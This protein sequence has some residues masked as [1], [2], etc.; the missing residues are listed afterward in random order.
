MSTTLEPKTSKLIADDTE[1]RQARIA[2]E[3]LAPAQLDHW[4]VAAPSGSSVT[5]PTELSSLLTKILQA[6]AEG[7]TV[8]VSTMPEDVTTTTAATMLGV[9]RPTLMKMVANGDIASH[10]VGSHTRLKSTDVQEFKRARLA[11]QRAAFEE[12]LELEGE[13]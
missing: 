13:R 10:K 6:F 5:M 3:E 7:R 11:R 8:T 12:L 4:V 2:V 1:V 9:S